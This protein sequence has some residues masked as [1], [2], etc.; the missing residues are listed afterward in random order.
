VKGALPSQT[1]LKI[2]DNNVTPQGFGAL[3]QVLSFYGRMAPE[4]KVVFAKYLLQRTH[5]KEP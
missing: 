1:F 4:D 2:S 3:E 5:N